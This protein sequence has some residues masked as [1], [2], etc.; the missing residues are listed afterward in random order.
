MIVSYEQQLRALTSIYPCEPEDPYG[1]QNSPEIRLWF[2][3][4]TCY[5][6][7]LRN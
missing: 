3:S 7:L 4:D 5:P 2:A 1:T 6:W